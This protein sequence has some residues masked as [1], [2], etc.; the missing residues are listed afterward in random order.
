MEL[1]LSQGPQEMSAVLFFDHPE[2]KSVERGY[3]GNW[4][5]RENN[6]LQR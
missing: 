1:S 3:L 4:G 6:S 2:M 5:W